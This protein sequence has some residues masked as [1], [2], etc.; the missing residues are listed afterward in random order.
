MGHGDPSSSTH[1]NMG[2]DTEQGED[3]LLGLLAGK[4]EGIVEEKPT[5]RIGAIGNFEPV[6]EGRNNRCSP[7]I[8][9]DVKIGL[10]EEEGG[11][12]G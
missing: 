4:V 5:R 3:L 8:L 7:P 12:G 10:G 6:A 9:F 2:I 11:G 1:I